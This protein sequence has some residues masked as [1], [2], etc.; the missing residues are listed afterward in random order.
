MGVR[1]SKPLLASMCLFAILVTV[2]LASVDIRA[3]RGASITGDEPFYLLTTQSLIQDRD[4]DLKNQ[5]EAKSYESFFDH[6]KGLWRQ[7]VSLEDGKLLSPHNPGLSVL[8]IPGFLAGG[9]IGAQLQMIILTALTFGFMYLLL[10]SIIGNRWVTWLAT[11]SV[12]TSATP[13]IYSSEI[14]PEIPAALILVFSL[15]LIRNPE[16]TNIRG[17]I[18]LVLLLSLLPWFGVK[19]LP[20]SAL[21]ALWALYSIP[22][23][24]RLVFITMGAINAGFFIWFHLETFNSL[25]P[26]SIG[27]VYAG[28][29]TLEIVGDHLGFK[30][31]FYRIIGLFVDNRFGLGRWAP[32]LL[33]VLPGLPLLWRL[34]GLPR[35]IVLLIAVQILIAT[36]VAITMMG[37]WFAGRTLMTT[38]PL[39]V[40]P[41]ILLFD[42]CMVLGRLFMGVLAIYTAVLTIVLAIA[43]Y[44]REVVIAV[45]PFELS[46]PLFQ[47]TSLLFPDYSLW[48]FRTWALTALWA[49]LFVGI[50]LEFYLKSDW[51]EIVLRFK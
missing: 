34:R 26:Y 22:K 27:A 28:D 5:Y 16:R 2:F 51:K 29:N 4:L 8:L 50:A 46:T 47:L 11:L 37:W 25:T 36:F 38:V 21:I 24:M 10:T 12:A 40:L 20:L 6:P 32:I 39:M 13:F 45:D 1:I 41:V 49:G 48:D 43:G 15:L 17:T 44:L 30:D 9:L 23:R 14:Y 18:T 42:R 31:R 33:V 35:L 3:T 7:S 19:Y